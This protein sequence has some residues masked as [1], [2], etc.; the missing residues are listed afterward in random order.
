[1]PAPSVPPTRPRPGRMSGSPRR[2]ARSCTP[3]TCTRAR[4]PARRS[5]AAARRC[6]S[7]RRTLA[8]WR[9]GCPSCG[10]SR[11][12]WTPPCSRSGAR[13][14]RALGRAAGRAPRPASR[15]LPLGPCLL[16]PSLGPCLQKGG[17]WV[18][19]VTLACAAAAR[20][21]LRLQPGAAHACM[22]PK[23]WAQ[24]G[25]GDPGSGR[26]GRGCAVTTGVPALSGM[27]LHSVSLHKGGASP[28]QR[29]A[30]AGAATPA[31]QAEAVPP[32]SVQLQAVSRMVSGA[33]GARNHRLGREMPSSQCA[34]RSYKQGS[35]KRRPCALR[36]APPRAAPKVAGLRACSYRGYGLSE[37]S[38]SERGLQQ[39][40]QAA[41]EHLLTRPDV[42]PGRVRARAPRPRT[43]AEDAPQDAHCCRAPRTLLHRGSCPAGALRPRAGRRRRRW[44]APR[45]R[46]RRRPALAGTLRPPRRSERPVRAH[47]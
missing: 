31:A 10:C 8:T 20:S 21:L 22:R 3:G 43:R 9:C 4:C 39:D 45:R 17:R 29:S 44:A 15:A 40:A 19:R 41:L 37:G 33:D 30:N 11:A 35:W 32:G 46:M 6:C 24:V 1:V 42:H 2:T 25:H 36:V 23:P 14:P 26:Q 27:C 7:C 16:C 28:R 5:G 34:C 13:A 18:P 12:T 38:P 47:R